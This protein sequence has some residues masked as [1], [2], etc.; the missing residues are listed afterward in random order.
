MFEQAIQR[1]HALFDRMELTA[2]IIGSMV[3]R[4]TVMIMPY[5]LHGNEDKRVF[6]EFQKEVENLAIDLGG[7]RVGLGLYFAPSLSAIH[8]PEAIALMQA[9]KRCIDPDNIMNPAK[10]VTG[11]DIL[12]GQKPF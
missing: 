3:D 2:A 12:Q 9:M 8:T 5:Y 10:T 1:I 11:T 4:N 7:R 6:I